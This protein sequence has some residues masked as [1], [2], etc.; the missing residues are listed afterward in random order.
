MK[1]SDYLAGAEHPEANLAGYNEVAP[2]TFLEEHFPEEALPLTVLT[3]GTGEVTATLEEGMLS[4]T[5]SF[6]H[7]HLFDFFREKV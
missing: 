7:Y 4:L 2:C 6:S 1:G 5:G 3:D